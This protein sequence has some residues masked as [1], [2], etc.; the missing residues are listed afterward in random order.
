MAHTRSARFEHHGVAVGI[1]RW[2]TFVSVN[3]I[4]KISSIDVLKLNVYEFLFKILQT[5]YH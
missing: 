1:A 2:Q 4:I 5:F 3:Q